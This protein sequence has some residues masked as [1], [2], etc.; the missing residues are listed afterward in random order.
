MFNTTK[1]SNKRLTLTFAGIISL[2]ISNVY[3]ASDGVNYKYEGN[4]WTGLCA[5]VRFN[6]LKI[7]SDY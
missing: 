7:L 4:E 2:F 3:T 6:L 1:N 5:T